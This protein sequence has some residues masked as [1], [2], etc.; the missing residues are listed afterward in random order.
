[1][2]QLLSPR[3]RITIL[4]Q[5]PFNH[6]PAS[7]QSTSLELDHTTEPNPD[8]SDAFNVMERPATPPDP[9]Q[10]PSLPEARRNY[11]AADTLVVVQG[12]VHTSDVSQPGSSETNEGTPRRASSVPPQE[13]GVHDATTP[14]KTLS[15]IL[16]DFL[17][18]LNLRRSSLSLCHEQPLRTYVLKDWSSLTPAS[19]ATHWAN[20]LPL[21]L[22]PISC[23]IP[24]VDIV[25]YRGLTTQ[26]T[27]E[28][29]EQ[30]RSNYAMCAVNPSR[31]GKT[32]DDAALHEIVYLE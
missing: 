5:T 26:H 1:M 28:R 2:S 14:F 19:L 11:P 21:P 18:P 3:Y 7:I 6:D 23:Q 27:V 9:S 30:G 32:F 24:L 29:D 15:R 13:T 16:K 20:S 8:N 25:F 12:V 10:A 17:S 31:V 4:L 22:S